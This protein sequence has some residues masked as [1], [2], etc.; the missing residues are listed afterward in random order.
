MSQSLTKEE[1]LL[2]F[3][4]RH[5]TETVGLLLGLTVIVASKGNPGVGHKEW[6][7]SK[8]DEIYPNSAPCETLDQSWAEVRRSLAA[9]LRICLA[10]L[11]ETP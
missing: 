8:S 7:E 5:H 3:A 2:L 9:T 1:S 10:R 4:V 11:E 6:I